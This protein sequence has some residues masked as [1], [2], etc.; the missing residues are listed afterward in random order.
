MMDSMNM[1]LDVMQHQLLS[2]AA[3][4]DLRNMEKRA[5]AAA[6]VAWQ[7][8]MM[9]RLLGTSCFVE[10][11]AHEAGFSRNVCNKYPQAHIYAFEA[12]P[13]VFQKYEA[14]LKAD[15]PAMDYRNAA[16][17]AEDGVSE[18][19]L[20]TDIDGSSEPMAGKR[21]S[22]L[23]RLGDGNSTTSISVPAVRLDTFLRQEN[24]TEEK[25]CLWIDVEG[26]TGQVLTGAE[27]SLAQVTSLFV[28]V[29]LNPVWDGQWTFR[30]VME[31]CY[32]HDF[33]PVLRDFLYGN[34]FNC[35]FVNRAY[36]NRIESDLMAYIQRTV[37][38][39]IEGV[40]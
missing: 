28:E 24:L 40:Q 35:I 36:Y 7:F 5:S 22:L 12:N 14:E 31:W 10:I 23:P 8:L 29:E 13:Y 20:A 21:S 16:V 37:R 26:A 2:Q 34:Q 11:G 30:Q 32:R 6:R 33:L 3:W 4:Y 19:L 27:S 39:R 1:F 25:V 15:F 38:H 17:S 9:Q 18:F